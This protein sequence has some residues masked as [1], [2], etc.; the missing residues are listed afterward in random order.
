MGQL[1]TWEH[2]SHILHNKSR[3]FVMLTF[4][5]SFFRHIPRPCPIPSRQAYGLTCTS[6]WARD[7]RPRARQ[8]FLIISRY[9]AFMH[10]K[11]NHNI[12]SLLN[13]NF[14]S[15]LSITI[16][17]YLYNC[18]PVSISLYTMLGVFPPSESFSNTFSLFPEVHRENPTYN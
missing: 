16:I 10:I 11:L 5:L 7:L 12:I 2:L 15:N 14:Q 3:L 13:L 6:R 9:N 8:F 1:W 18:N 4:I 17:I